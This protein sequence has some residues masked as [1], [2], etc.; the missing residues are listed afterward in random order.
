MFKF[1]FSYAR[2][3]WLEIIV[4][5]ALTILSAQ[6]NLELPGYTS[7]II[8]EGV[9]VN[10]MARVYALG[11]QMIGL[12]LLGGA[13]MILSMFFSTRIAAGIARDLR[14]DTFEKIESF[15][16]NEFNKFAVSSLITR[17]TNDASQVQQ[18]FSMSLR[19]GVY[20]IFIGVGAIINVFSLSI[21]MSWVVAGLV[22]SILILTGTLIAVVIPKLEEIQKNIDALNLQTRQTLT[23]LRIIRA[24]RNDQFEEQKFAKVNKRNAKTN[25][26]VDKVFG[27]ISPYMTMISGLASVAVVWLASYFVKDGSMQVGD[28]F[29]LVQYVGQVGFAFIM[30]SMIFS[31]LP[32]M[33]VSG[34][35]IREV[36][37]TELTVQNVSKTLKIP[38][39]FDI[40]FENVSFKYEDGEDY[41][42]KDLNFEI[43][44]G[45]TVAVI[46][47]TGS[48]KSTVA[49]LIP[50]FFDVSKG[51]IKIGG[52][53]IAKLKQAELH[54]LIGYA[55]QKASL[56]SGDVRANVAYGS[57]L[58]D[59]EII[60]ALKIAQAWDFVQNLP[61]DL[62]ESVSQ[63]GKN[64]SGGQKQ[65]L[66][67]ARAIARKAPIM[68]FDDSFS[69]LDY[70][71][72]AALRAELTQKTQG[73]TKFI[74]AQRV[75]SIAHADKIIV[76][77][78]GKIEAIGKHGELL[79]SNAL[80]R[81]IASSQLSESEIE[82]Q[83]AKF[84][85][86]K[87]S[88]KVSKNTKS[89]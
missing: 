8:N 84:E 64:F 82:A 19:M 49:K 80:Y 50:R 74:V 78:D 73:K 35:R 76:L 31:F 24:F 86:S 70:K 87:S 16:L 85:K 34:G 4:M 63:G 13:V 42:L 56:F 65:R 53:D 54:D 45:E 22:A 15:S 17:V 61:N 47:G 81:E 46:G 10:D 29:A 38:S 75:A 71:T 3:F 88:K 5:L 48:G 21:S 51:K 28:I 2:K 18:T 11:W 6:I 1:I 7:R 67:I 72:D 43:A 32:R 66:S 33:A 41:V 40:Q 59:E 57:D 30:L 20:A 52:R 83:I 44:E 14:K 79:K 69:A 23:G 89:T 77:N 58:T 27:L 55:P 39:K 26:F 37:D 36:L 12:A 60:E 62:S 68:I 9:A 25:T